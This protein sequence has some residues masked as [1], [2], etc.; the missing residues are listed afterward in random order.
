MVPPGA[1]RFQCFNCYAILAVP[2]NDTGRRQRA[3]E[4]LQW[5]R[6]HSNERFVRRVGPDNR[7]RWVR[8]LSKDDQEA[9][10][11]HEQSRA[12]LAAVDLE[13]QL[14][15]LPTKELKHRL[16]LLGIDLPVSCIEK[17]DVVRMLANSAAQLEQLPVQE[18]KSRLEA[19]GMDTGG[20]LEKRELLQRMQYIAVSGVGGRGFVRVVKSDGAL[21]F[22]DAMDFSMDAC[23]PNIGV[24]AADLKDAA[25]LPFD[26]KVGWFRSMLQRLR[27]PWEQGHVSC[28]VRRANL[29]E[30][31]FAC[32]ARLSADD[33]R[34]I[35][36][37]QFAGEPA[38]DAGGVAR[39]WFELVSIAL[40]NVD[41][42]LWEYGAVD[43]LAYKINASAEVANDNAAAYF[44]FAGRL[45]GKALF[46]SQ[47]VAPHLVLPYYK[48]MLAWPIMLR[49][50]EYVD[51]TVHRSLEQV[52]ELEDPSML[53]LDFTAGRTVFGTQV[54]EELKPG[55]E[56]MEVT[57]ENRAE[58]AELVLRHLVFSTVEGP[59]GRLLRGFYDVI[60]PP[61]LAV[62]DPRELELLLC[63]MPD[64]DVAD[65][66]RHT[67]YRGEYE[68]RRDTHRVIRWFWEALGE[69]NHEQRARL[70][71]FATGTSRVPVQG[72]KALQGSDGNIK[73]FTI[74]GCT[75]G[76][77]PRAHTCFNR[78]E[79]PQYA[80][81]DDLKKYVRI[82]IEAESSGF[83][84]E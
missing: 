52:L 57:R 73:L 79:L 62:F 23:F 35:F 5:E 69:F 66:Q 4:I 60:P 19:M 56:N 7:L 17:D 43:N 1:P 83:G 36:R 72:F 37:F 29:L 46:D 28:T 45:L 49:D 59:L 6:N 63:G 13:A 76:L 47:Q 61:L 48:H 38:Q 50:L 11:E 34:R 41:M 21:S 32:F 16:H 55:G 64:I 84:Q 3:G 58:Y 14:R 54:Q 40:F 25:G 75:T 15:E 27:T 51:A 67:H 24:T 81:K 33:M 12:E 82:A 80:S 74:E 22:V 53:C 9:M 2:G 20:C 65:W 78:L 70:L 31:S 42:G 71:Q 77:L 18:L 8:V 44:Y 68:S 26:Q 30:D 10:R 39:E